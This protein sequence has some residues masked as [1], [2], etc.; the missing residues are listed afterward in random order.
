M[1]KTATS[2]DY[3]FEDYR[4]NIRKNKIMRAYKGRSTTRGR[5]MGIMNIEELATLWHFPAESVVKA[6]L[7]QKAP[8][9]KAGPPIQL[10]IGEEIVSEESPEPIFLE[11]EKNGHGEDFFV[12]GREIREKKDKKISSPPTDLPVA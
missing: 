8:G 1:D 12:K 4:V 3:F 5:R 10:P 7:I 9:R 6:P 2:V 11:E